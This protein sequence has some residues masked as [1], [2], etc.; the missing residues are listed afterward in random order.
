MPHKSPMDINIIKENYSRLETEELMKLFD[1]LSN[2][3][4]EAVLALQEELLKRGEK[5]LVLKISE[6]LAST[7]FKISEERIMNYTLVLRNKGVSESEIDAELTESFGIDKDYI[8]YS[9]DRIKAK[10]KEN[11]TIGIVLIVF[12]LFLIIMSLILGGYAGIGALFIMGFG[13]WRLVIGINLLKKKH[14]K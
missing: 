10:G 7:R 14:M 9:K 2:L 3:T 11:L 1:Q 6:Y 12:P 4:P 13:I 5:K 8:N